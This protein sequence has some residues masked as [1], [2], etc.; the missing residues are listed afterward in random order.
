LVLAAP[1]GLEQQL[2]LSAATDLE[3]KLHVTP[4][5]LLDQWQPVTVDSPAMYA[6]AKQINQ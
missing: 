4:L 5:L 2:T 1:N 6:V 3:A